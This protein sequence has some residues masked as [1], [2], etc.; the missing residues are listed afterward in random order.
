MSLREEEMRVACGGDQ[1]SPRS[2][3]SRSA[4]SGATSQAIHHAT[5]SAT[6]TR[7]LP[8]SHRSTHHAPSLNFAASCRWV[9]PARLRS[10]RR[11]AGTGRYIKAWFR[12][13]GMPWHVQASLA[14]SVLRRYRV[15]LNGAGVSPLVVAARVVIRPDQLLETCMS[16]PNIENRDAR[17]TVSPPPLEAGDGGRPQL[18]DPPKLPG[19]ALWP[20]FVF[21]VVSIGCFPLLGPLCV[22][23]VGWL[24]IPSVR[25]G[26][27]RFWQGTLKARGR[28][29]AVPTLALCA[30][31]AAMWI[32]FMYR[33][34]NPDTGFAL[35]PAAP[36]SNASSAS[37]SQ[38]IAGNQAD[39]RDARESV[40][41]SHAGSSDGSPKAATDAPV[42]LSVSERLR[43]S[44][45]WA[46]WEAVNALTRV[47]P[48]DP[49][50]LADLT[51]K[52]QGY[53]TKWGASKELDHLRQTAQ[54][55]EGQSA[56]WR[57]ANNFTGTM[58][59][60]IGSCCSSIRWHIAHTVALRDLPALDGS[61]QEIR[62]ACGAGG[63]RE[64]ASTQGSSMDEQKVTLAV[65][66]DGRGQ[67]RGQRATLEVTKADSLVGLSVH[68]QVADR[69]MP[70]AV[71]Q[72]GNPS[73]AMP[74]A[75]KLL[76]NRPEWVN[77]AISAATPKNAEAIAGQLDKWASLPL[78]E[79]VGLTADRKGM[80]WQRELSLPDGSTSMC[81][82]TASGGDLIIWPPR[83]S[84]AMK[85][86]STLLSAK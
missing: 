32:S 68:W 30:V 39:T 62:R 61:A 42:A 58:Q 59:R 50:S 22:A 37:G 18:P 46:D 77:A 23:A 27:D 78:E 85:E 69:E 38:S 76:G 66:L 60:E 13:V 41:T 17:V 4:W 44:P 83:R 7:L 1:R 47:P 63:L 15:A 52:L 53:A 48:R 36:V 20:W 33:A 54:R 8:I 55:F 12:F 49:G 64:L 9:R 43:L 51:A 6:S 29:P 16:D 73:L 82:M 28:W 21:A 2:A 26:L 75:Q 74:R 80:T 84:E 56:K 70:E 25:R 34:S 10:E 11:N 72:M 57:D 40:N 31:S 45:E 86:A 19:T 67:P 5:N 14:C 3:N 24:T 35:S 71:S 79:F 81:L 65:A